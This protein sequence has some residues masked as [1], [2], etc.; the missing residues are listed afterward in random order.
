MFIVTLLV[1]VLVLV[2]MWK[3]FAKAGEPGWAVIV[4]IY[5]TLVFLKIAGKPWWWLLLMM[6]PVVGIVV[7]IMATAALARKF[8][9]GTGFVVGMILVPIVFYPILGFGGSQYN[10]QA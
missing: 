5:N 2:G 8:G 10:A 1:F 7:A 3:V 4:P 9:Q 6:I